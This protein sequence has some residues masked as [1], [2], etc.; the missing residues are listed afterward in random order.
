MVYPAKVGCGFSIALIRRPPEP[1]TG[2]SI[3][4]ADSLSAL[5][6]Q[7]KHVLPVRIPKLRC[8]AV[9]A[10]RFAEIFIDPA[11]VI[12]ILSLLELAP[13]VRLI[14]LPCIPVSTALLRFCCICMS[15]S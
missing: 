3:I 2:L 10:G 13:A 1:H 4:K 8:F 5:V 7:A 11:P 14:G 6:H 9:P 15:P 12:V